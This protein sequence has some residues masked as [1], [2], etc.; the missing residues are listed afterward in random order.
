MGRAPSASGG[1]CQNEIKFQSL[2][3]DS[4]GARPRPSTRASSWRVG[5]NPSVGIH[6]ARAVFGRRGTLSVPLRF[7]P[8]V[9]IHG[10]R[11]TATP[12]DVPTSTPRFNPSVGIHG[13]RASVCRGSSGGPASAPTS[14]TLVHPAYS[15]ASSRFST[16]PPVISI[17]F[18]FSTQRLSLLQAHSRVQARSPLSGGVPAVSLGSGCGAMTHPVYFT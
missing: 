5:F 2:C 18:N 17:S 6:G 1:N 11:A 12:T 7:N 4:W 3:R 15:R 13:A 14:L 10:A 16:L 8:S 9:G